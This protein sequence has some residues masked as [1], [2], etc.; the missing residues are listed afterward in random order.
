MSSFPNLNEAAGTSQPSSSNTVPTVEE[1]IQS[2]PTTNNQMTLEQAI[3]M[4]GNYEVLDNLFEE[5]RHVMLMQDPRQKPD[6][7]TESQ[8][9]ELQSNLN[10]LIRKFRREYPDI[11]ANYLKLKN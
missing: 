9:N 8:V 11:V 1:I 3:E 10:R 7:P 4:D 5:L 6:H 2:V